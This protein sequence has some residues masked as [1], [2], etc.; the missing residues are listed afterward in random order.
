M[1]EAEI[2][3]R[4]CTNPEKGYNLR[5]GG[6]RNVPVASVG[7]NIS[8][9]KM[10]HEVTQDV[11]ERLSREGTR[12]VGQYSLDGEFIAAY[13]SITIAAN[14]V[15]GKKTNISAVCRGKK[16]RHIGGSNG[17]I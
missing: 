6:T 11:R 17:H 10:G 12:P 5:H 15:G 7:R 3:K 16:N 4:D 13:P 2:A 8:A 1:E 9:A 14:T